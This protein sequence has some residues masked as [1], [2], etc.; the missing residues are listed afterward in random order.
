MCNI[1][2]S[3][4]DRRIIVFLFIGGLLLVCSGYVAAQRGPAKAKRVVVST[5]DAKASYE[6]LGLVSCRSGKAGGSIVS[7]IE[8]TLAEEGANLG[9]DAV[10]SMRF[11]SHAGYI[12]GYGTAVK[13][14]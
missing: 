7:D 5:S 1:I 14:K 2:R 10:V 9:A 12:Y 6:V 13:F 11:L 4:F 8:K 3:V